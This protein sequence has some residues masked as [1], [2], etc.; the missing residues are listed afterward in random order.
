MGVFHWHRQT[1]STP[2]EIS[3]SFRNEVSL[4]KKDR[5]EAIG[6]FI[7]S[8]IP[9]LRNMGDLVTKSLPMARHRCLA[10]LH[11]LSLPIVDDERDDSVSPK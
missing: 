7:V 11:L 9:G 4:E 3:T 1:I 2:S 6:R 10:V 5:V 8:F